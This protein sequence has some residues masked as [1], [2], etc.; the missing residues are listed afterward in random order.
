MEYLTDM[1]NIIKCVKLYNI[2]EYIAGFQTARRILFRLAVSS[3]NKILQYFVCEIYYFVDFY[4][5]RLYT[6]KRESKR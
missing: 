5:L 3:L 2:A 4:E 6:N 1:S